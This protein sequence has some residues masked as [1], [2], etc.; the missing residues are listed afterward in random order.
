VAKADNFKLWRGGAFT[1]L[2]SVFPPLCF[3]NADR[4][5]ACRVHQYLSYLQAFAWVASSE[6][7]LY[8]PIFLIM[9]CP[10]LKTKQF[11]PYHHCCYYYLRTKKERHLFRA[12]RNYSLAGNRLKRSWLYTLMFYKVEA[13]FKA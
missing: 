3:Y 12:H 13:I 1:I 11:T 10:S 9:I 7:P 2:S 5:R 8:S 6:L 4:F